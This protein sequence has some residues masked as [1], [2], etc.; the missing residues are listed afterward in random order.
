MALW[1]NG[2]DLSQFATAWDKVHI[3]RYLGQHGRH[4]AGVMGGAAHGGDDGRVRPVGAAA[5]RHPDPD[6]ARPCRRCSCPPIVLLVPLYLTVVEVP[7]FG[8]SMVNDYWALWL[9]ASAS[10]R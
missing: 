7:I 6:G 2:F 10:A 3:D 9:P 5:A 4:R 1:P 8:F